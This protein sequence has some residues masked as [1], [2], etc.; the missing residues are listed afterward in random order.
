PEAL[1]LLIP[2]LANDPKV[3][4][5]AALKAVSQL[6]VV[7]YMFLVG[8]ELNGARLAGRAHAAIAVSHSSIVVPFVLGAGLALGLYPVFSHQGVP[9][10]S[11]ALFLGVAM[12]ITA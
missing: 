5:P 8:L 4:V 9:F 1:N 3:Q 10:T 11:F 6:G 7:L 2:S 12:S